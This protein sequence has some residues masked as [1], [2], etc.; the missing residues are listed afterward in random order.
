MITVWNINPNHYKGQEETI[1]YEKIFIE[2][3]THGVVLKRRGK[4]DP[5][6]IILPIAGDDDNWF[7]TASGW[8]SFYLPMYIRLME[9]VQRWLEA[10]CEKEPN[11]F[12]WRF[13]DESN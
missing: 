10:N 5:H 13:K 4:N 7:L 2:G 3:D 6:V 11:G 12:G 9:E 1:K 8:S